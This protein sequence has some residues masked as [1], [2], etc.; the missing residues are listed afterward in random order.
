M[1]STSSDTVSPVS[2]LSYNRPAASCNSPPRVSL[3]TSMTHPINISWIVPE[4]LIEGLSLDPLSA[5][6][7]LFDVYTTASLYHHYYEAVRN[8]F[9]ASQ[10]RGSR[11]Y[12]RPN[13]IGNLAL[14]SCPGKKVRLSGPVRGRATINRDLDLDFQRLKS[15]DISMIIWY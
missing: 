10:K 9:Q 4:E 11:T 7:D 14:S 13:L 15:S 12:H 3:K 2:S 1:A 6:I 8:T 5:S